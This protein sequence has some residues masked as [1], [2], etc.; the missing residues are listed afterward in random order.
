M[1]SVLLKAKSKENLNLL[2]E[3]AKKLDVEVSVISEKALE[4]IAMVSAIQNDRTGQL[5]DSNEFL[6]SLKSDFSD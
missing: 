3:L 1:N 5:V 2:I 6:N 4:D